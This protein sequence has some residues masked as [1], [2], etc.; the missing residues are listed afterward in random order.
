[1]TQMAA[2]QGRRALIVVDVQNDSCERR[3]LAA[4]SGFEGATTK[5][6]SL[7]AWLR[8]HDISDVDVCGIATDHCVHATALDPARQGFATRVLLD[9][10]AAVTRDRVAD[11]T[12]QFADAGVA[13][14]GDLPTLSTS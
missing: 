1:M 2:G 8:A 12:R 4:Y 10:T 11:V 5:G 3:S 6:E 14:L 9:L 7:A 13:V